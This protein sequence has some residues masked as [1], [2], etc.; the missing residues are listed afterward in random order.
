MYRVLPYKTQPKNMNEQQH[1]SVKSESNTKKALFRFRKYS[2]LGK[3]SVCMFA[4]S[5]LLFSWPS[6]TQ[7]TQQSENLTDKTITKTNTNSADLSPSFTI[8]QDTS[9][10]E[11]RDMSITA[12]GSRVL[13]RRN[14]L[15]PDSIQPPKRIPIKNKPEERLLTNKVYPAGKPQITKIINPP[16]PFFVDT[17]QLKKIPIKDITIPASSPKPVEASLPQFRSNA[18]Y[19]IQQLG[20]DQGMINSHITFVYKDKR[21][22]MWFATHDGATRYDGKNLTTFTSKQGL[23]DNLTLSILEDSKGNFWFGS[24]GGL[25]RHDGTTV[26]NFTTKEEFTYN[27]VYNILEDNKGKIWFVGTGGLYRFDGTYLTNF[28]TKAG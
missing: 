10:V 27:Q 15:H 16:T 12:G 14:N 18:N 11:V 24:L 25:S 20:I 17:S 6:C 5:L 22:R 13:S 2:I 7:S 9:R 28:T 4:I 3:F 8:K 26:T 19:D 1:K 23:E 21:D